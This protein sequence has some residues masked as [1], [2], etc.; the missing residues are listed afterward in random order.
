[1]RKIFLIAVVSGLLWTMSRPELGLAYEVLGK[2]WI[3]AIA[4]GL[5][6]RSEFGEALVGWFQRRRPAID[7]YLMDPKAPIVL[8]KLLWILVLAVFWTLS[9]FFPER[10]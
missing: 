8:R 3:L 7:A 5:V 4:A 10:R 1:M 2:V 9:K 6:A